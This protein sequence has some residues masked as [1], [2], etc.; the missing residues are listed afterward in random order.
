MSNTPAD[1]AQPRPTAKW[2]PRSLPALNESADDPGPVEPPRE[3]SVNEMLARAQSGRSP[4]SLAPA[5]QGEP[6]PD[7]Y[8][9]FREAKRENARHMLELES[10]GHIKLSNQQAFDYQREGRNR[11]DIGFTEAAGKTSFGGDKSFAEY[12]PIVGVV[13]EGVEI[14]NIIGASK[15]FSRGEGTRA[16]SDLIAQFLNWNDRSMSAGGIG[17]AVTGQFFSTIGEVFIAGGVAG[18]IGVTTARKAAIA[19]VRKMIGDMAVEGVASGA[20][21]VAVNT[22]NKLGAKKVIKNKF[23]QGVGKVAMVPVKVAG[24]AIPWGSEQMVMQTAI[25]QTVSALATM[26]EDGEGNFFTSTGSRLMNATQLYYLQDRYGY[27]VTEDG[28]SVIE[29]QGVGLLDKMPRAAFELTV[30]MIAEGTG[31]ALGDTIIALNKALNITFIDATVDYLMR[32]GVSRSVATATVFRNIKTIGWD[33]LIGEGFEEGVGAAIMQVAGHVTG[34]KQWLK[35]NEEFYDPTNLKGLAIGIFLGGG[36]MMTVGGGLHGAANRL[37]TVS[38]ERLRADRKNLARGSS[39]EQQ[40]REEAIRAARDKATGQGT[41]VRNNLSR[42]DYDE[43]ARLYRAEAEHDA[44]I[45]AGAEGKDLEDASVNFRVISD[46]AD[47][48]TDAVTEGTKA[49]SEMSPEARVEELQ[50]LR[51]RSDIIRFQPDGSPRAIEGFDRAAPADAPEAQGA[52][53]GEQVGLSWEVVEDPKPGTPPHQSLVDAAE[54]GAVDAQWDLGVHLEETGDMVGA[55]EQYRAAAAQGDIEAQQA[56]DAIP[57]HLLADPPAPEAQEETP[58]EKSSRLTLELS[59]LQDAEAVAS[60]DQG[61]DPQEAVKANEAIVAAEGALADAMLAEQALD[62]GPSIED[63]VGGAEAAIERGGTS[64]TDTKLADTEPSNRDKL[65]GEGDHKTRAHYDS[66]LNREAWE[67]AKSNAKSPGEMV[68]YHE[69]SDKQ[70]VMVNIHSRA[71]KAVVFVRNLGGGPALYTDGVVVYDAELTNKSVNT[72]TIDGRNQP[73]MLSAAQAVEAHFL[74]ESFH[75]LADKY[76]LVWIGNMAKM[77]DKMMPG[78]RRENAAKYKQQHDAA[79]ARAKAKGEPVPPPLTEADLFEESVSRTM[80]SFINHLGV[81]A[82]SNDIQVFRRMLADQGSRSVMRTMYEMLRGALSAIPGVPEQRVKNIKPLRDAIGGLE[83]MS[84]TQVIASVAIMEELMSAWVGAGRNLDGHEQTILSWKGEARAKV[85]EAYEAAQAPAP[86]AA[87]PDAQD[88]EAIPVVEPPPVAAPAEPAVLSSWRAVAPG[89]H[90]ATLPDGSQYTVTSSKVLDP[91]SKGKAT[92]EVELVS[93]D[94]KTTSVGSEQLLRNAKA[95][96]GRHL[97]EQAAPIAD[98]IADPIAA[99]A[100]QP[101]ATPKPQPRRKA[102]KKKAKKKKAKR[103]LNDADEAEVVSYNKDEGTVRW[104]LGPY[105]SLDEMKAAT[106]EELTGNP[107]ADTLAAHMPGEM[108][109]AIDYSREQAGLARNAASDLQALKDGLE[110]GQLPTRSQLREAQ[111]AIKEANKF[112]EYIRPPKLLGS[113]DDPLDTAPFTSMPNL[114]LGRQG[115]AITLDTGVDLEGISLD[116]AGPEM[117]LQLDRAIQGTIRHAKYMDSFASAYDLANDILDDVIEAGT[118]EISKEYDAATDVAGRVRAVG[119]FAQALEAKRLESSPE[120]ATETPFTAMTFGQLLGETF[121]THLA[122]AEINARFKELESTLNDLEKSNP[123]ATETMMFPIERVRQSLVDS[124]REAYNERFPVG[125][126]VKALGQAI[127]AALKINIDEPGADYAGNMEILVAAG[128][129]VMKHSIDNPVP[130]AFLD[131]AAASDIDPLQAELNLRRWATADGGDIMR[132]ADGSYMLGVH[133]TPNRFASFGREVNPKDYHFVSLDPTYGAQQYGYLNTHRSPDSFPDP[134]GAVTGDG[135]FSHTVLVRSKRAYDAERPAD[136]RDFRKALLKVKGSNLQSLVATLLLGRDAAIEAWQNEGKGMEVWHTDAIH[137]QLHEAYKQ[138]TEHLRE[139]GV[140]NQPFNLK[141]G[142]F[143]VEG[144]ANNKK[145]LKLVDAILTQQLEPSPLS[146]REAEESARY[147]DDGRYEVLMDDWAAIEGEKSLTPAQVLAQA[148]R[149]WNPLAKEAPSMDAVDNFLGDTNWPSMETP[150][151][152]AALKMAGFDAMFVKEGHRHKNLAVF[153]GSSMKSVANTGEFGNTANVSRNL[154]DLVDLGPLDRTVGA[155]LNSTLGQEARIPNALALTQPVG[156]SVTEP[157]PDPDPSDTTRVVR[158]FVLG[159]DG[160]PS[161]FA[162]DMERGYQGRGVF[163]VKAMDLDVEGSSANIIHH[164]L[165]NGAA[166]ISVES[167]AEAMAIAKRFE[168]PKRMLG[169]IPRTASVTRD[170][171]R[172]A[173]GVSY[174]QYRQ[175]GA[176]YALGLAKA[177]RSVYEALTGRTTWKDRDVRFN[178]GENADPLPELRS[179]DNGMANLEIYEAHLGSYLSRLDR[180]DVANGVRSKRFEDRIK[181]AAPDDIDRNNAAKIGKW[182]NEMG[183]AIHIRIDTENALLREPGLTVEGLI[184]RHRATAKA[185]GI[186]W[187]VQQEADLKNSMELKGDMLKL[188]EDL[189]YDNH[190]LGQAL[191]KAGLISSAAEFYSA[192]IWTA[193][194][195][196]LDSRSTVDIMASGRGAPLTG[197]TAGGRHLTSVGGRG[198]ARSYDSILEGW[199]NGRELAIDNALVASNRVHADGLEALHNLAVRKSLVD[200][201]VLMRPNAKRPVPV[202]QDGK[203]WVRIN[204]PSAALQDYYAPISVAKELKALTSRI[205][206]EQ[207]VGGKYL[208]GIYKM[209]STAKATLLFTSLF[210]HQAFMRSFFYSIPGEHVGSAAS[211]AAIVA[212]ASAISVKNPEKAT[213]MLMRSRHA[214]EGLAATMGMIPEI[215]EGV[216]AGLTL[217]VGMSYSTVADMNNDWRRTFIERAVAKMG[218]E[219]TAGKLADARVQSSNWLFNTLGTSLKSQSFL[220]EYRHELKRHSKQLREGTMS[221]EEIAERVA[222]KTNDNFGG[223]NLRRGSQIIGGTRSAGTQ[224]LMRLFFLAPDWTESNF[225]TAYKMVRTTATDEINGKLTSEGTRRMEQEMYGGLY[226][227]AAIRSQIPTLLWNALMAGLDDEETIQSLYGKAWNDGSPLNILKA[228]VTPIARMVE[229]LFGQSDK[230]HADSR[231]YFSLLGHFLDPVKWL[232]SWNRDITG[233]IK[234]K[235]GPIGRATANFANGDNWRGQSFTELGIWSDRDKTLLNGHMREWK[236]ADRGT[237]L[238]ELPS[239]FLDTIL[240]NMPIAGQSVLETAFGQE[241]GFDLIGTALGFHLSRTNQNGRTATNAD[242]GAR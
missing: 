183:R 77:M 99:P 65:T 48:T 197:T 238:S 178:L 70:K 39:L 150:H 111:R 103:N 50:R 52:P 136:N 60:R 158:G 217:S 137:K 91:D 208:R 218:A 33:G 110:S 86:R 138:L 206:W 56:L 84:D 51:D 194:A 225:N 212:A 11:E 213:A 140:H 83:S 168:R 195:I 24:K 96:V 203:P 198:K 5:G 184:E 16:D 94:G 186:E 147:E 142:D 182:I 4:K 222:S 125:T 205:D 63:Q 69:L 107:V 105:D 214:R 54:A 207:M 155:R 102:K 80:E 74:H 10:A 98:P 167:E 116:K 211:E 144:K 199:A 35:S 128:A 15:R 73:K 13:G 134:L 209:Q 177:K 172:W 93:P 133:A 170:G 31:A 129:S 131:Q 181:A 118:I 79:V 193:K 166:S 1:P 161:V 46:A 2:D 47:A 109:R 191:K 40:E 216:D 71:N 6:A 87:N 179:D 127:D 163:V 236:F 196:D 220:L 89:E 145:L 157:R 171:D 228:D 232:L 119:K 139:N 7:R 101:E 143:K 67:R 239:W 75:R 234:G 44:R 130:T 180:D 188:M 37:M 215:M 189:S 223:L 162:G 124:V 95:L 219:G 66:P 156:L 153:D 200:A 226:L 76:G 61:R 68:P 135:L 154:S 3:P 62:G 240:G 17:G 21:K 132:N 229:A 146:D 227:K 8:E 112:I 18:K 34:D 41:P 92:W 28:L 53:G 106:F 72:R 58:A 126:A 235:L 97:A 100:S 23:V 36:G 148:V 165:L 160:K 115:W 230:H 113:R 175:A 14:S 185:L 59:D 85:K 190:I 204:T 104:N 45:A 233:P 64:G 151:S 22:A 81:M 43:A 176:R 27:E 152:V 237:S 231:V 26:D 88:D 122:E 201:G 108:S 9:A 241:T 19:K 117:A 173:V 30:Q 187:S 159:P 120:E 149:S 25:S 32:K 221:K 164:A 38:E 78:M 82:S 123:G 29:N 121:S 224:L 20:I 12:M 90:S 242:L 174:A 210:H 192:R 49:F 169:F 57:P 42:D 55:A 141:A 114:A 202:D